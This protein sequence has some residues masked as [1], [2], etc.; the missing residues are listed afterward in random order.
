[1]QARAKAEEVQQSFDRE[2]TTERRGVLNEAKH[3]L[4]DTYNKLKGEE[5]MEK[6][7]R[8]EAAQGEKT[9]WGVMEG[10]K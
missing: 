5:L 4:F 6:V 9:V 3:K 7:W 10:H 2:R 1:M 8:V